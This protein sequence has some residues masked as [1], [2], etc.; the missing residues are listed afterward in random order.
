M[1]LFCSGSEQ[2]DNMPRHLKTVASQYL[3]TMGKAW[4]QRK[5]F[6]TKDGRLGLGPKNIRANDA[7]CVL[8]YGSSLFILRQDD[9]ENLYQLIGEAYVQGVLPGEA[10]VL[11]GRNKDE[12]FILR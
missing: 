11:P 7:V 4:R 8:Y 5:Y 12:D 10:E 3:D 6:G 9:D 1:K 2:S